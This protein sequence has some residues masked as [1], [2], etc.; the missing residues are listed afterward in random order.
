S[1]TWLRSSPKRKESWPRRWRQAGP[2]QEREGTPSQN[3]VDAVGDLA[4]SWLVHP[5]GNNI[6]QPDVSCRARLEDWC[7]P[8]VQCS[9]HPVGD[10]MPA[11]VNLLCVI[12]LQDEA[13]V[14]D[15]RSVRALVDPVAAWLDDCAFELR[16]FE[17]SS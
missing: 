8:R 13:H 1:G 12:G 3:L 11:H 6:V 2:Q 7:N 9:L 14:Q 17:A 4:R 15:V 10:P 5:H 16:A